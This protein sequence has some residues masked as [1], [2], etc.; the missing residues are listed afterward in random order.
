MNKI[1]VRGMLG[2]AMLMACYGTS[3]ACE[4]SE[5]K[6]GTPYSAVL[7]KLTENGNPIVE[8]P[9]GTIISTDNENLICTTCIFNSEKR[10]CKVFISRFILVNTPKGWTPIYQ[11]LARDLYLKYGWDSEQRYHE[12]LS[13]S[14]DPAVERPTFFLSNKIN[15]LCYLKWVDSDLSTVSLQPNWAEG[16]GFAVNLLMTSGEETPANAK[17]TTGNL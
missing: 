5:A 8:K 3:K 17:P 1:A 7:K 10:L 4:W 11:A 12:A 13:I 2:V 14:T 16:F 6:W 15:L 9:D